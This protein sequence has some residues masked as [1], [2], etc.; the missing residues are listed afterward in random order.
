MCVTGE[1]GQRC[2]A[3]KLKHSLTLSDAEVFRSQKL[4]ARAHET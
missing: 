1:G 4:I 2:R 3:L